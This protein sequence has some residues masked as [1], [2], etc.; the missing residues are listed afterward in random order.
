[1]NRHTLPYWIFTVLTA[2]ALFGGALGNLTSN[3]EMTSTF[4][5]LGYPSYMHAILGV[6]T[7]GAA[8][9]ILAPGLPRLKEW[10]Y[11]GLTF[12]MTGAALSHLAS[13]D[14][15]VSALP[16]LVVLSVALLSWWLRPTSRRLDARSHT[17]PR[18]VNASLHEPLSLSTQP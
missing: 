11:A 16:P 3:P 14:P 7:L 5:R 9:T 13:H 6:W 15:L 2:L 17:L 12:E 10:A 18:A 4:A 8:L 1:M